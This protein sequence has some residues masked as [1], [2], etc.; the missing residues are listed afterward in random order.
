MEDVN[1]DLTQLLYVVAGAAVGASLKF[2]YDAWSGHIAWKRQL[3]IR[4]RK[5]IEFQ[6]SSY[7]K[8]S[9]YAKVLSDNLKTY[10]QIKSNLQ[11]MSLVPGESIKCI[12][13][14]PAYA[15]M[16]HEAERIAKVS[17]FNAGKF[18]RVL[19]DHF[20]DHGMDYFL[21]DYWA[22]RSLEDLQYAFNEVLPFDP[23]TLLKYVKEDTE[24]L[25]FFKAIESHDDLKELHKKYFDWL[26]KEDIG[27]KSLSDYAYAYD[28]LFDQQI[29][30]FNR[31]WYERSH[32]WLQKITFQKTVK[33]YDSAD[34]RGME[35]EFSKLRPETDKLI[36]IFAKSRSKVDKEDL[37]LKLTE[38]EDDMELGYVNS[39][40][41]TGWKHYS[42]EEYDLAIKVYKN[43]KEWLERY[44]EENLERSDEE[45]KKQVY[46]KRAEKV[47]ERKMSI[48]CNNLGNV[49]SNLGIIEK[50]N[51]KRAEKDIYK[52]KYFEK[53]KK[54][55]KKAESSYKYAIKYYNLECGDGKEIG[56]ECSRNNHIYHVNYGI[57]CQKRGKFYAEV[58]R[59]GFKIKEEKG[60]EP[61][62]IAL[63][64]YEKSIRLFKKAIVFNHNLPLIYRN[65]SNKHKDISYYYHLIGNAYC[66]RIELLKK[67]SKKGKEDSKKRKADYYNALENHQLAISLNPTEHI[68][69]LHLADFYEKEGET[70]K[71]SYYRCKGIRKARN[72]VNK[73]VLDDY[74]E[75]L[76]K[77]IEGI[78]ELGENLNDGELDDKYHEEC[79][80]AKESL[81]ILLTTRGIRR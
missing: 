27:V 29:D 52:E 34:Y 39:L 80:K 9:N 72:V 3:Q 43:A 16:S 61:E 62:K 47:F 67:M 14:N 24:S 65:I 7:R 81:S 57:L 21:P 45:N 19:S 48:I 32:S 12:R 38:L 59:K 23:F 46:K 69:Y 1:M 75:D 42:K 40:I 41:N 18:L 55:F 4:T 37:E 77:I 22:T 17:L 63:K 50:N 54:Y 51:F 2:L 53:A 78:P 30:L 26:L 66:W 15:S 36:S 79:R 76:E 5:K 70:K 8:M 11:I 60:S 28:N 56:E 31:N 73:E 13:S 64:C 20:L 71:A 25:D 68:F 6:A 10:L 58:Y 44:A 49:Y 74:V 33:K 35:T